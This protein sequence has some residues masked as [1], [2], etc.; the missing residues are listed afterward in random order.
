[1]DSTKKSGDIWEIVAIKYLQKNN[2]KIIDTNFKYWRYWEIDIISNI[3]DLTV[4]IEVK[5]RKNLNFWLPE[6]SVTKSKLRKFSKTIDYYCF[7]NKISYEKIRFDV[8]AILKWENSYKITHY[9]NLW[10]K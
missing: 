1:M 8:I 2:Y 4:F 7:K 3:D 5:Y 10:V 6:E 9:K